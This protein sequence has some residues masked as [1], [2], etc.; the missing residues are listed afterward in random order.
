MMMTAI[1]PGFNRA[2]TPIFNRFEGIATAM[3]KV[4]EHGG[5][6][7]TFNDYMKLFSTNLASVSSGIT[8]VFGGGLQGLIAQMG[9]GL[10]ALIVGFSGLWVAIAPLLPYILLVV[11]ALFILQRMWVNNVGGMQTTWL[12]FTGQLRTEWSRFIVEFDRTMREL[13]PVIEPLVHFIGDV[14]ILALQG[15]TTA[16]HEIN[17]YMS[18]MARYIADVKTNSEELIA[19]LKTVL[20]YLNILPE[21]KVVKEKIASEREISAIEMTPFTGTQTT[22]NQRSANIVNNVAIY[23]SGTIDKESGTYLTDLISRALIT[24]ARVL[25]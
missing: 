17:Y 1:L 22:N 6:I 7:N 9:V 5:F 8:K 23:P 11:G 19:P 18:E 15:L 16:L 2:I 24:S 20:D 14:L 3:R 25:I 13:G 12:K 21:S 10:K 4:E